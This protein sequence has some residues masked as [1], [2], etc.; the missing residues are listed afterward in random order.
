MP[1]KEPRRAEGGGFLGTG[2]AI[3]NAGRSER[4]GVAWG[5]A[6]A[7][8]NASGASDPSL[9]GAFPSGGGTRR[10]SKYLYWTESSL[11][12]FGHLGTNAGQ[13]ARIGLVFPPLGQVGLGQRCVDLR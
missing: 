1:W 4:E 6:S 2:V 3:S 9:E 12:Q 13:Q 5:C 10:L 7:V 8:S 11:S